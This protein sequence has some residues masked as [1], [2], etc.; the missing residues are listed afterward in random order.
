MLGFS[1]VSAKMPVVVFPDWNRIGKDVRVPF[2]SD[3]MLDKLDQSNYSR[4]L[5]ACSSVMT[6][7]HFSKFGFVEEDHQSKH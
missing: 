3:K 2:L 5:A 4:N 7:C 6:R 1:A